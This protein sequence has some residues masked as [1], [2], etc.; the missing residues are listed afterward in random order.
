MKKRIY[1]LVISISALSLYHTQNKGVG[2]NTQNPQGILHI[3]GAKDNPPT[4]NIIKPSQQ[5]NDVIVDWTGKIGTGNISPTSKIDLRNSGDGAVG[6][7]NSSLTGV[8]ADGGAVRYNSGIEYSNGQNWYKLLNS[9]TKNKVVV[10]ANKTTN[11]VKL[12]TP[13]GITNNGLQNRQSNYLV[14]WQKIYEANGTNTFDAST[15]I[16]TAPRDGVYVAVFTVDLQAL[17]FNFNSAATLNPLQ[18]E[19][20]WQL[21][22]NTTGLTSTNIIN[23]VKCANTYSS[24]TSTG[25]SL[26]SG[27]YCSASI[28]M[29]KN[30]RLMPYIWFNLNSSIAPNFSLNNTGGY[31]NLTISEQ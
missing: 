5:V 14:D 19:A 25:V 26:D 21:Y 15:G 8:S 7:G 13:L 27:S 4:G 31:N 22:D 1:L 12:I 10:I 17:Q 30:E 18:T 24:N 20:I 29:K 2:I 3:D 23:T 16:F 9:I 11:N 6:F 28:Y